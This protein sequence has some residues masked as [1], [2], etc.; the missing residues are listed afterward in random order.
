[1]DASGG[2]LWPG[3]GENLRPLLWLLDLAAGRVSGVDTAIGILPRPDE[4]QLDGLTLSE[5][6]RAELFAI[7]GAAWRR[8]IAARSE[9]LAGFMRVPTVISEA[10][11][12]LEK[13]LNP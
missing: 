3:Y 1:R 9:L 13:R 8:E 10:H 2:Y 4:L 11:G 7:D 5:S 6:D 12:R